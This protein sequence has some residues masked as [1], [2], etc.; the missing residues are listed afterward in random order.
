M[1]IDITEFLNGTHDTDS[2]TACWRYAEFPAF[3]NPFSLEIHESTAGVMVVHRVY[4]TRLISERIAKLRK[5][6]W[7][8]LNQE[9]SGIS[10]RIPPLVSP[11]RDGV[12]CSF[13]FGESSTSLLVLAC[14]EQGS[15]DFGA[16]VDHATRWRDRLLALEWKNV[17][18]KS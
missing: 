18:L 1:S 5:K 12:I 9:L 11:G 8:E 14:W 2:R 16:L 3:S 10:I 15:S 13:R 7:D 6:P 4:N 17:E